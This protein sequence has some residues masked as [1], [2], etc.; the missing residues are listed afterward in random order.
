MTSVLTEFSIYY[1]GNSVFVA[2]IETWAWFAQP[3]TKD[4]FYIFKV[5]KNKTKPRMLSRD[6]SWPPE[7]KIFTAWHFT[8]KVC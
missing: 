6:L 3:Q 4:A 1:I 8:E 7:P 2:E 5:V